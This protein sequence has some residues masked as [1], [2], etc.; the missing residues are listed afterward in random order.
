MAKLPTLMEGHE[1]EVVVV[2]DRAVVRFFDN[3]PDAVRFGHTEYG[4]EQFIAQEVAMEEPSVV[5]YS[6]AI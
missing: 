5:S 1:G 2:H 3:M 4:P 6:L